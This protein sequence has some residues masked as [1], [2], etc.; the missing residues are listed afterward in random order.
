VRINGTMKNT[1]TLSIDAT[2]QLDIKNQKMI[3]T[4]ALG[5]WNGTAYTGTLGQVQTGRIVTTSNFASLTTVAVASADDIGKVGTSFGGIV[6]NSGD[7]LLMYTL[8]GDANLDA[9]IDA[10]DY[11]QIDSNYNKPAASHTYSKGDFNY[12]GKINGDDYAKIDASFAGQSGF[13]PAVLPG[14]VTAVPEPAS[15][16]SALMLGVVVGGLR[17]RRVRHQ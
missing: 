3:T 5:A 4:D 6:V 2:G 16:V 17:G 12:D 10:D 7:V 13:S 1:G 11:F 15:I 8:A 9:K 14:A